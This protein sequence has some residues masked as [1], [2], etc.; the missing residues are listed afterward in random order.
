MSVRG[1]DGDRQEEAGG[2]A[3]FSG[4][5][6][7]R[8]ERVRGRRRERVFTGAH[9]DGIAYARP[10]SCRGSTPAWAG[11]RGILTVRRV[12][13]AW[14]CTRR[15]VELGSGRRE[16]GAGRPGCGGSGAPAGMPATKKPEIAITSPGAERRDSDQGRT[17]DRRWGGRI[18][19]EIS[20]KS[21]GRSMMIQMPNGATSL[22]ASGLDTAGRGPL[23]PEAHPSRS[24]HSY[25]RPSFFVASGREREL[26]SLECLLPRLG[27]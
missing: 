24:G 15:R 13:L 18:P 8:V 3:R 11:I 20:A 17:A 12:G 26:R 23:D 22:H 25:R 7:S 21:A 6:W 19:R 14:P 16:P 10:V 2:S 4:P 1:W 5:V 9:H 27:G